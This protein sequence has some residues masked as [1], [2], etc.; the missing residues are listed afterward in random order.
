MTAL[1]GRAKSLRMG[2][3]YKQVNQN[4]TASSKARILGH[5]NEMANQR[6]LVLGDVGLDEYVWGAVRRISPEAP[7]PVLEVETED[8][9]SGLAANVAQNIS[10]LGGQSLLLGVTGQ[11]QVCEKLEEHLKS[12]GV[13]ENLFIKDPDR[14][15]TRK[16]RVMSGQHH[17]C[18]VDFEKKD[19]IS[20][21]IKAKILKTLEANIQN[22]SGLILQ[23]YGK[24]IFTEDLAQKCIELA[25]QHGKKVLVDPHRST[26]ITHFKGADFIKP[27]RE[28]AFILSGL[29]MEE[30]R[31]GVDGLLK[32]GQVLR[33]KTQCAHL[34]IT[35]GKDGVFIFSDGEVQ[36]IP[37]TSQ[38]VYDVTGAG[39]TFLASFSLAWLSGLSLQDAAVM[40]NAASGIVVGKIGC[41]PCQLDELKEALKP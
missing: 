22:I 41:V 18:R 37:T 35:Q 9:R 6:I 33:E 13:K 26:P 14:P 8:I 4:E 24:G 5:L 17:L 7:V 25:H 11:D 2:K 36:N 27:N 34:A 15:T 39:D 29:G 38:Q 23:D 12:Q 31:H 20:E 1:R 32:V 3:A 28:E 30:F 19:F 21:D 10:T 40:A 16:L